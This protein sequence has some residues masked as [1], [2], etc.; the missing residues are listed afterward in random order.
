MQVASSVRILSIPSNG[1]G[2]ADRDVFLQFSSNEL[3]SSLKRQGVN[4]ELAKPGGLEPGTGIW[5]VTD[6][7]IADIISVGCDLLVMGGY[8]HSRLRQ[9]VFGGVTR[10]MLDSMTVPVL[11]SH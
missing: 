10:R 11:M 7:I 3:A 2:N 6:E 1:F 9:V 5:S 8:G 4:C